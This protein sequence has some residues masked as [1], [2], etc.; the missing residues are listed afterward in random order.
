[1]TGRCP[2]S[3][4]GNWGYQHTFAKV[5][6]DAPIPMLLNICCQAFMAHHMGVVTWAWSHGRGHMGVA[7]LYSI[8]SICITCHT[9]V[10][11]IALIIKY[12]I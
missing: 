3:S 2:W 11:N 9:I 12:L 7:V 4:I 10:V 1:M 5:C 6:L 8:V